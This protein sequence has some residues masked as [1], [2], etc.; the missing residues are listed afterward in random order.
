MW[1]RQ[2][3]ALVYVA[4]ASYCSFHALFSIHSHLLFTPSLR[5]H[6][7][8]LVYA[9]HGISF[10]FALFRQY[11]V[12]LLPARYMNT[13]ETTTLRKY[14]FD[15]KLR[16]NVKW[17]NGTQSFLVRGAS[18]SLFSWP[19]SIPEEATL[20][21]FNSLDSNHDHVLSLNELLNMN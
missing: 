4:V 13:S 8:P 1:F 20:D 15:L 18:W 12:P 19:R 2:V 16:R 14:T 10:D 5:R 3:V 9:R 21:L 17:V 11:V 6:V 7:L